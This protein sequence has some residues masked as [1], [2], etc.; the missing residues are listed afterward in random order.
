VNSPTAEI[1]LA[2]AEDQLAVER[3]VRDAYA[4]Y[5]AHR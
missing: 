4:K 1:R 2:S 3:V 5:I